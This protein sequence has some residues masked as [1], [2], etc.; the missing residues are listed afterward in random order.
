MRAQFDHSIFD[1]DQEE[2]TDLVLGT[3]DSLCV[4][5]MQPFDVITPNGGTHLTGPGRTRHTGSDFHR[6]AQGTLRVR[7]NKNRV[8]HGQTPE[9]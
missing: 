2:P 4:I 3:L 8:G 6:D 1:R 9:S 7:T 5:I